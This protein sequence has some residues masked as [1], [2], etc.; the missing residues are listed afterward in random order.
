MIKSY[1]FISL[2]LSLIFVGMAGCT[3]KIDR[4]GFL[5]PV[6]IKIPN[7]IKNDKSKVEFIKASEKIINDLSDRFEN[8]ALHNKELL[9][10][11]EDELTVMD[12]IKLTKLSVE[13]ISVGESLNREL[14]KIN[15]YMDKKQEDGI[16]QPDLKVY[17]I[18]EKSI[19]ERI[20]QLDKKYNDYLKN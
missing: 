9:N 19:E 3:G 7:D 8:I 5:K 12:K 1:K 17:E 20:N 4:T 14:E 2:F 11:K 10:K 18:V 6:K 15:S 13:L 16:N